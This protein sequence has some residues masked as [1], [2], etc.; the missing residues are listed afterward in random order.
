MKTYVRQTIV[1]GMICLLTA[2][3]L[4][5]AEL[6]VRQ[7]ALDAQGRFWVYHNGPAHPPMPFLPYGWMSDET[8]MGNLFDIDLESTENPNTIEKSAGGS[9]SP[10]DPEKECCMKVKV[11]WGDATWGSIAFISGP[12]RPPWWGENNRGRHYDLSGL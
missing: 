10:A 3:S 4:R 6:K 9:A 8:N 12:D 7:P 5:A 1:A 2:A 11:N